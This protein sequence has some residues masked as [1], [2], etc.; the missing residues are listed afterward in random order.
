MS[1]T[2]PHA[3]ALTLHDASDDPV[4]NHTHDV[5]VTAGEVAHGT[6]GHWE[7]ER[8]RVHDRSHSHHGVGAHAAHVQT[9]RI[10]GEGDVGQEA[11]HINPPP[12]N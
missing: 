10:G 3:L 9:H 6:Q 8:V 7:Q 1:A 11:L 4:A 2:R 12:T 5:L